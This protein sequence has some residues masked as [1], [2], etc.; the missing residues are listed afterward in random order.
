M[1]P[2]KDDTPSARKAYVTIS[3]IVACSTVFLWQR[4]LDAS[5][6][7]RAVAAD[8]ARAAAQAPRRAVVCPLSAGS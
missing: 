2:L 4:S 6:S 8:A 3:L 1:I 7:R 5:E